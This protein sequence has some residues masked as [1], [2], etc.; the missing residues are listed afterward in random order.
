MIVNNINFTGHLTIFFSLIHFKLTNNRISC[1]N[2]NKIFLIHFQQSFFSKIP[3]KT[4]SNSISFI[5][6]R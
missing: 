1:K 3:G 2:A 4:T 6:L 5:T